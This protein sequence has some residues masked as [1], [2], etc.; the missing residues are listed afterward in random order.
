MAR[1]K[2]NGF[3]LTERQSQI[4]ALWLQRI[5]SRTI[6]EMLHINTGT[7]SSTIDRCV[8]DLGLSNRQELREYGL[9]HGLQ[10]VSA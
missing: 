4:L 10:E 3:E 7:V 1:P 9:S 2:R 6:A 5:K 8:Y